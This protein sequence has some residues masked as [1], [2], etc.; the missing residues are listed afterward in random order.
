MWQRN[1]IESLPEG[2]KIST[3]ADDAVCPM[4]GTMY[5]EDFN[6]N[7]WIFCDGCN[8]RF[9]LKCTSIQNEKIP[10]KYFCEKYMWTANQNDLAIATILMMYNYFILKLS[11]WY[12]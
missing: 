7:V 4:C 12:L 9:D 3:S 1:T 6:N 2:L 5:S 11:W 8:L 10:D